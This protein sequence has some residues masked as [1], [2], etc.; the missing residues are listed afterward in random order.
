MFLL[1]LLPILSYLSTALSA[2]ARRSCSVSSSSGIQVEKHVAAFAKA[3]KTGETVVRPT[4]TGAVIPSSVLIAPSATKL[5]V[6]A[7]FDKGNWGSWGG[8]KSSTAPVPSTNTA[9]SA[10]QSAG[11][12]AVNT[13]VPTVA[14]PPLSSSA[15]SA[16]PITGSAVASAPSVAAS[17]PATSTANTATGGGISSGGGGAAGFGLDDTAWSKITN[18]PGLGWYW[19]W[20]VT[21]FQMQAE[22]VPCVFGKVVAEAFTG[23]VPAGTTHIMSF[24]EPDQSSDVG[25]CA[26]PDVAEGARLHQQWTSKLTSDVKIGAP[27]VARGGDQTWFKPWVTACAGNCK[28]D[29]IP[30]HFY[31]TVVEDLISYIKAFPSGGKPIWVTEFS[32][33]DYSTGESCDVDKQKTFVASAI[34]WFKGEGSAYVERW[35]WFGAI[36]KYSGEHWG[37]EGPD[38]TLNELGQYYL[39]L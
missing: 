28:Y 30:I 15:I 35:A 6:V 33:H 1:A 12:V 14:S 19:N 26:I 22:F 38:G 21:P 23:A 11:T 2:P 20:G 25:G 16:F 3:T 31:G 32:C 34:Q 10:T 37:M 9:L 36:P 27:A 8:P 5:G 17:P 24:N 4:G 29:F 13:E 39:T 18:T 7:A